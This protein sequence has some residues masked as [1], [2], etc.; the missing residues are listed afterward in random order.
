MIDTD[1]YVELLLLA[2]EYIYKTVK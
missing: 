2:A 1:F